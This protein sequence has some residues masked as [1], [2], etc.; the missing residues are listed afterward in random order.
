[1]HFRHPLFLIAS[2]TAGFAF[3]QEPASQQPP[4][5]SAVYRCGNG[6]YGQAPCTGG[7]LMN[8]PRVSRSF[9]PGPPPQDRARKMARAQLPPE[10][11]KQCAT[12]EAAIRREEARQKS[13]ARA[14][15]EAEEGDLAI[16]RVTF[17]EMR[18]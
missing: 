9:D 18:C 2:C 13:G 7:Q 12:L 10:T 4:P 1:M 11:Q 15:T 14:P 8:G 17:R 6:Q 5:P 3:A 16:Q